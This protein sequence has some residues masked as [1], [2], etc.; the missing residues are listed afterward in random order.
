[1]IQN[2][3][4]ITDIPEYMDLL[5]FVLEN[6]CDPYATD[7]DGCLASHYAYNGTCEA[8]YLFNHSAKGDLWDAAL[9]YF[10]YDILETRR[11][12]PRKARYTHGYTRRDFER[13]WRG[14][15]GNCPY[16]DDKTWPAFGE[17]DTVENLWPPM[18]G[19]LCEACQDCVM[20]LAC[21][22]CGVCQSSLEYFCDDNHQH[23]VFCPREQVAAWVLQEEE[24]TVCWERVPFSDSESDDAVSSSEDSEDGGI[25]LQDRLE[26]ALSDTSAE[27]VS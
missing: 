16:W 18:R 11:H 24:D 22:C 14:R 4:W 17:I 27:E 2:F 23:N 20:K 7:D 12:Y 15:E 19:Q 25:L 21:F 10:G 26:E 3:Y 5:M 13:M 8:D 6:G 9:T 1:M